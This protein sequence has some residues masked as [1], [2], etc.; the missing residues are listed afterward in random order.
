MNLVQKYAPWLY[1]FWKFSRPHTVIGTSLS[2]LG[3]YV[4]S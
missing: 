4:V 3:L 1:A 2:V